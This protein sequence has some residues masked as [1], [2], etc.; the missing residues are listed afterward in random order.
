MVPLKEFLANHSCLRGA[1]P[2]SVGML[3]LKEFLCKAMSPNF[4][5][6]PHSEGM[7]PLSLLLYIF[8]LSKLLRDPN[9]FFK[10]R[11]QSYFCRNTSAD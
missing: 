1:D 7:D 11:D 6:R 10:S 9:Y 3:P 8:S 2:N 4:G 5:I